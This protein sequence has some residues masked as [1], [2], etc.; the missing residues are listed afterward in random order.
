MLV[1]R[2]VQLTY[3]LHVRRLRVITFGSREHVSV[4]PSTSRANKTEPSRSWVAVPRRR[5]SRS[6]ATLQRIKQLDNVGGLV[7]R[8]ISA[9]EQHLAVAQ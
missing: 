9:C 5:A 4:R 1:P 6:N 8:E 7:V 3:A 2:V